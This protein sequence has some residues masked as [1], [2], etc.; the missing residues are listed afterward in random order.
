MKSKTIR[1]EDVNPN[2]LI[3]GKRLKDMN[4]TVSELAEILRVK[5][6]Y[7]REYLI[8]RKGAP[9][10]P[11]SKLKGQVFINGQE[12]YEWAVEF[13][14]QKLE[15]KAENA[16][17]DNEFLCCRCRKHVVPDHFSIEVSASGIPFRKATCPLCGA[18]INRYI[19]NKE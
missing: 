18:I 2:L 13:H 10:Q 5:P 16:L 1:K 17:K 19:K 4:Y 14:Q 15:K 6:R 3:Y 11:K 12:L 7:I 8:A 9:V